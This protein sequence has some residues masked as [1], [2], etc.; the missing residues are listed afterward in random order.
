MRHRMCVLALIALIGR[1][2]AAL[3]QGTADETPSKLAHETGVKSVTSGT[4]V[5][6]QGRFV[7][8]TDLYL[9]EGGSW[10]LVSGHGSDTPFKK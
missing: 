3:A 7:R 4:L 5:V 1:A 6:V 10:K 2:P 8:G 9:W